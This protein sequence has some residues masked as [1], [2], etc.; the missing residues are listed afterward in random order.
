MEKWQEI[1]EQYTKRLTNQ[2][3]EDLI[4]RRI[5]SGLALPGSIKNIGQVEHQLLGGN[6]SENTLYD[7][8]LAIFNYCYTKKLGKFDLHCET[9]EIKGHPD[10]INRIVSI[11]ITEPSNFTDVFFTRIKNTDSSFT[12]IWERKD[13]F[14]TKYKPPY[15]VLADPT[16]DI[17]DEF[18]NGAVILV[19][20]TE[21]FIKQFGP[22]SE[23]A[24]IRIM[25]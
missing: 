8:V 5:W 21:H 9:L 24:N 10:I 22:Y 19:M 2:N 16:S 14:A 11:S 17:T 20:N 6:W 12:Y 13:L 23:L 18:D 25:K 3:A 1:K 4:A 7:R 15:H